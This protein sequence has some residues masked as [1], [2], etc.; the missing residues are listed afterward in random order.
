[1]VPMD[2]PTPRSTRTR[3]ERAA[4]ARAERE[5]RQRL[6]EKLA[7]PYDGLV[8][9]AMLHEAGLTRGQV[10]SQIERGAWRAVGHHTISITGAEPVGRATW[11]WALWESGQHAALD[12]VTSL[13]AAGLKGWTETMVHVSVPNNATVRPLDGV[14]HHRPRRLGRVIDTDLRRTAPEVAAI[15]AAQGARSDRA[16]ATL[17]AMVVQQRL[18]LPATLLEAWSG[19]RATA[20]R[21]FLTAVIGDVCDGAH[22]LAE[23]D[24]AAMCRQRGLPEPTRQAMRAGV[25]GRVYLDVLWEEF[26][27]HVEIQGVHHN[28]GLAGIDDALRNNDLQVRKSAKIS[29]QIPV[30]GLRVNPDAF[31]HQV[32]QALAAQQDPAA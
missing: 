21:A 27:V 2:T 25:N 18:V 26:G 5:R 7:E 23:L 15:R 4:A 16:A 14:R 30:L 6:A 20:R 12:G 28:Q 13:L 9:R 10:R 32:Q 17:L 3:A 1:M 8:T 24:F 22:S 29:L 19:V 31:L 11:W